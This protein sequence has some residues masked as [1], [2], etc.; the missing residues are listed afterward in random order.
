LLV[1]VRRPSRTIERRRSIRDE[2]ATSCRM[3]AEPSLRS[4]V[5]LL[6]APTRLD[7]SSVAGHADDRE[8]W[9]NLRDA[10]PHPYGIEDANRWIDRLSSESPR[11]N[12]AIDVDG[13]VVGGIGLRPGRDI[14]RYSAEL[15]YWLGREYWGHGIAT[16]AVCLL[17]DY[18]FERLD[19]QRIF[20][21]SMVWNAASSR[22]LEKAGFNREGTLQDACFKDGRFSDI[23][24]YAIVRSVSAE[25]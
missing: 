18:A 12:Y 13:A 4:N 8:V 23:F 25:S 9:R 24:I 14:E 6:R 22:V 19:L 1:P 15:G 7:A 10:F 17:C 11:Y 5:C 16:A 20:A 21:L 2:D 3:M